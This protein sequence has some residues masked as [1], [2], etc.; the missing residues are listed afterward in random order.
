MKP[1]IVILSSV[2]EAKDF[3]LHFDLAVPGLGPVWLRSELP[4]V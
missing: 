1:K 3:H 4:L 2:L